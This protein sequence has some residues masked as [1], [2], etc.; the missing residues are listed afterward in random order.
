MG[1]TPADTAREIAA[2]RAEADRLLGVLDVRVQRSLEAPKRLA[3]HPALAP[4]LGAVA[5]L[6]VLLLWYRSWRRAV[7]KRRLAAERRQAELVAE[8]LGLPREAL[9]PREARPPVEPAAEEPSLVQRTLAAI[10]ASAVLA[11]VDLLARRLS[12]LQSSRIHRAPAEAPRPA[13]APPP[14][15]E[16]PPAIAKPEGAKV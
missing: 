6:T 4:I 2:L 9:V 15:P 3:A 8:R 7:R 14:Q 5:V 12:E 11:G 13:L 16:P 10:V 1:E